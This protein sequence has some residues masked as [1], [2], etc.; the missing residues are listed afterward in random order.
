MNVASQ[1]P[2][3]FLGFSPAAAAILVIAATTVFR[4]FYCT[5]LPMLPDET[6]YFQWSRHLDA[7]YFS[8]GPGVAYTIWAGTHLFGDNNLGVR[9][10]AVMLSAGTAWQMFQLARR[11][12]DESTALIAVLITNVIPI[13][14]LG[15]VVMTIDPLSAFFWI[16]AANLFSGAIQNDR[17]L[18][19]ALAGFAVG[20]GFLAKY[21][22]ALELLAF[23]AFLSVMP[24]RRALLVK[25]GFWIMLAVAILCTTPVWWWNYQHGWVSAHQLGTRGKLDGPFNVQVST[26]VEFLG[27]QALVISPWL[28]LGLLSTAV[29]AFILAWRRKASEKKEGEILLLILFVPVFLMY[30]VLSWHLRCEPNWPAV[31]YLSLIIVMASQWRKIFVARGTGQAFIVFAFCF[32]WLQTLLMQDTVFLHLPQKLDPMGRVVGWTEIANRVNQLR[33]EQQPEVV[34][35]DG[36]KEASIFSFYLPDKYFIYTTRHEAPSNQYDFWPSYLVKNPKRALWITDTHEPPI[37][38]LHNDFTTI[39]FVERMTVSFHGKPFRE[40]TVFLC[41]RKDHAASP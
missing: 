29:I 6:Y 26:F 15:A 20:C 25:P 7:S 27:L 2:T 3:R 16:W 24:V 11:W 31:S 9:F 35:T 5:W 4:L 38:A 8:K 13:Y 39:K 32:A 18:D 37:L 1:P 34:I 21:L 10:F 28:F 33:V 19:W 23:L 14:A 40:Y 22:N 36:Y 41:E 12:Y 30:A 17:W